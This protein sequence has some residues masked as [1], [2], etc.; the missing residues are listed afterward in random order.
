MVLGGQPDHRITAADHPHL[1]AAYEGWRRAGLGWVR[2][3]P[4]RAYLAAIAVTQAPPETPAN[5][6]LT[7]ASL[8]AGLPSAQVPAALLCCAGAL[9]L[10]D[11]VHAHRLDP[12]LEAVLP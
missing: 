11:R 9:E 4:D 2:L 10:A 8:P 3:N 5:A 1:W 12:D 6:A 7:R